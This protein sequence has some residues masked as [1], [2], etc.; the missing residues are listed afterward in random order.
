MLPVAIQVKDTRL[1]RPGTPSVSMQ[2][3]VFFCDGHVHAVTAAPD[4][5]V[6]GPPVSWVSLVGTSGVLDSHVKLDGPCSARPLVAA[7]SGGW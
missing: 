3:T 6:Y 7:P 4:S 5:P 2:G 1:T